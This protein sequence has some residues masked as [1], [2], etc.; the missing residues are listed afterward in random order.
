MR[1]FSSYKKGFNINLRKIQCQQSEEK[2]VHIEKYSFSE[3]FK[4]I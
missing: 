1:I 3:K 2:R 4:L